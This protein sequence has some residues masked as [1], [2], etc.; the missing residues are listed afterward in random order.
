LN[1]LFSP[2]AYLTEESAHGVLDQVIENVRGNRDFLN[3]IDR[4]TIVRTVLT[5]LLAGVVSLKH[6]GFREER[7]WRAIYTPRTWPSEPMES[8][9][10]VI[11]GIPQIVYQVPLD[12]T[13][14]DAWLTST[15][16]G[17]LIG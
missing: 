9:T 10:R 12:A 17:C 13:V 2:V 15:Y 16:R 7:E 3:T 14:S 11:S 1:V 8:A 5:M 4:P 6:V